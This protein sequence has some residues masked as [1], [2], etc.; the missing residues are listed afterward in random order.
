M[1]FSLL[2]S[3]PSLTRMKA[4]FEGDAFC[5]F[6]VRNEKMLRGKGDRKGVG[7]RATV[8]LHC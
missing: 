8:M 5:G 2:N 1:M 4:A 3:L 6:E 7:V